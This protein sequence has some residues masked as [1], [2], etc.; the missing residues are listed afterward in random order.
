MLI[1]R[2]ELANAFRLK[3]STSGF[4][5]TVVRP[6][7]QAALNAFLNNADNKK[8]LT[9]YRATSCQVSCLMSKNDSAAYIILQPKNLPARVLALEPQTGITKE[10]DGDAEKVIE[11][12][13]FYD[14]FDNTNRLADGLR[15]AVNE[16]AADRPAS[17]PSLTPVTF[18]ER[19]IEANLR[20]LQNEGS[21]QL[22]NLVNEIWAAKENGK[23]YWNLLRAAED[24]MA[25]I[26]KN[27]Q[28]DLREKIGKIES[29]Y[30]IAITQLS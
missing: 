17:L 6:D 26:V 19:E 5:A 13:Q 20:F 9:S 10:I 14:K 23:P 2:A 29:D 12:A 22:V 16:L 8:L 25:A 15:M 28:K 1:S 7:E 4:S 18:S 30:N 11:L 3:S 27:R 21:S 24:E